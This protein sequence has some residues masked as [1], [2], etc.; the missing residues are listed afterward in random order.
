MRPQEISFFLRR[1]PSIENRKRLISIAR[2]KKSTL[3]WPNVLPRRRYSGK[4]FIH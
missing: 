2:S 4:V 3:K 1:P